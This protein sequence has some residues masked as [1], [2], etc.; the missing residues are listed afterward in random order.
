MAVAL[1]Q[2]LP[3]SNGKIP[4]IGILSYLF[5][6]SETHKHQGIDI[7]K[8][9]GT[10]VRSVT[11]GIVTDTGNELTEHF[12]GYGRFVQIEFVEPPLLPIWILYAHLDHIN[13]NP[14]DTIT[15]GQQIGT[16]GKTCFN[17][18]DPY[19]ECDGSH[20]HFEIRSKQYLPAEGGRY[21]PVVFLA[22]HGQIP[23]QKLVEIKNEEK[24]RN[25]L[26]TVSVI[27]A[28]SIIGYFLYKKVL[29]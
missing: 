28:L 6:R 4:V 2:S 11:D 10:I 7:P 21:D 29:R 20:L 24:Q 8:P 16:V 27:S 13:V 9:V 25:N 1:I 5:P 14:G 17:K 26:I 12:S 23:V 22:Q 18:I 19:K 3:V 15:K